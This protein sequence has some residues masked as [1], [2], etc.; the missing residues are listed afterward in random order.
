[1]TYSTQRSSLKLNNFRIVLHFLDTTVHM[2][3]FPLLAQ[4]ACNLNH[5]LQQ[6]QKRLGQPPLIPTWKDIKWVSELCSV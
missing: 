3:D 2:R 1:M 4:F 6:S 5:Y